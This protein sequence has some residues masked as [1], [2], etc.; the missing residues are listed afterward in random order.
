MV[1]E[2]TRSTPER[3]IMN[4]PTKEYKAKIEANNWHEHLELDAL[5]AAIKHRVGSKPHWHWVRNPDCKYIDIRIDM[6][7]G[8]WVLLNRDRERISPD[9]LKH[10]EDY[11]TSN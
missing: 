2:P 9:Q 6:R 5:I 8:G 3:S 4:K 7:D 10:Q 1:G 11:G